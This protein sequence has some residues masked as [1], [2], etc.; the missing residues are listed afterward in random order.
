M[1]AGGRSLLQGYGRRGERVEVNEVREGARERDFATA[2]D[3]LRRHRE[4]DI[5]VEGPGVLLD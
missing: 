1:R 2:T 4:V 5:F 3:R